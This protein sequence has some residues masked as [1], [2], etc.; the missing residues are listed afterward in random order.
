MERDADIVSRG[1]LSASAFAEIF[2]DFVEPISW[3]ALAFFVVVVISVFG[4]GNSAFAVF[5]SRQLQ[6]SAY[7]GGAGGGWV[8]PTP[9]HEGQWG[10]APAWDYQG[11]PG[12]RLMSPGR[13]AIEPYK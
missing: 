8:P 2:N 11:S 3:K 7:V 13:P 12:K 1:K 5:R 10:T 9:Q 4:V 6:N